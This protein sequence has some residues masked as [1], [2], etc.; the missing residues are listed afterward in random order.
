MYLPRY[1][2]IFMPNL[3]G[4]EISGNSFLKHFC[5]RYFF[6]PDI[7]FQKFKATIISENRFSLCV[8]VKANQNFA[9]WISRSESLSSKRRIP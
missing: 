7:A 4:N 9:K 6:V 2:L 3:I 1:P 5:E 8:A